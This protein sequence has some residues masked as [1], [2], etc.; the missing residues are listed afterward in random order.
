MKLEYC[1]TWKQKKSIIKFDFS[2]KLC[3]TKKTI[4]FKIVYLQKI[5]KF[6][7]RC[8]ILVIF[9]KNMIKNQI[10]IFHQKY[11]IRKKHH[12]LKLYAWEH[13]I[14]E[15]SSKFMWDSNF[16]FIELFIIYIFFILIKKIV[17]MKIKNPIFKLIY[18]KY[19]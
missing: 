16:L 3:D 1:K 6:F 4:N 11:A 17:K 2:V 18:A 14:I 12:N 19:E 15:E 8:M 13:V 10:S 5:Y 9:F 7:T